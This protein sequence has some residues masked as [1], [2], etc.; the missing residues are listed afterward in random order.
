MSSFFPGRFRR[1][2]CGDSRCGQS[3]SRKVF[4]SSWPKAS[5][6]PEYLNRTR[7][8]WPGIRASREFWMASRTRPAAWLSRAS[9]VKN[10]PSMGSTLI[11]PSDIGRKRHS[12][13]RSLQCG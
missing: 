4:R 12:T 6:G 13:V 11:S 5:L 3:P 2:Q 1:P 9:V 10:S 7:T 8:F